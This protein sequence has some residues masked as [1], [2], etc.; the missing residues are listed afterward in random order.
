MVVLVPR[1]N[2]LAT[3]HW[4]RYKYKFL[5]FKAN[6][7][8]KAEILDLIQVI[9]YMDIHLISFHTKEPDRNPI[10]LALEKTCFFCKTCGSIEE[11]G[12]KE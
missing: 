7:E 1:L 11:L 8:V 12:D 6:E 3:E 2:H 4:F 10:S 5:F 9:G